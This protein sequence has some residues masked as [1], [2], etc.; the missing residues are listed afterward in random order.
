M[1]SGST[2]QG[3]PPP[4]QRAKRGMVGAAKSLLRLLLVIPEEVYRSKIVAKKRARG[5]V[6]LLDRDYFTDFYAHDIAP[7][8]L[9]ERSLAQRIHAYY[10]TKFYRKPDMVIMLDAPAAILYARKGEGTPAQLEK[11][12]NEYRQLAGL[13][14]S[15]EIID[16]R[17]PLGQVVERVIALIDEQ[18]AAQRDG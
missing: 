2:H 14:E 11:R 13:V 10:L 17:A 8:V 12:A 7:A 6:V 4:L 16:V 15:F 1:L 9:S 18:R 5:Q 3:G